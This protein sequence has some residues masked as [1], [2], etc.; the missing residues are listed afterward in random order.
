MAMKTNVGAIDK[1][2][3]IGVGLLL[4]LLT[5]TGTIGWW[6]WIG[7]VPLVTGV[8]GSCPAYALLGLNTCPLQGKSE[9]THETSS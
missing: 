2:I 3:R 5:L 9:G 8:M 1:S 6:G 7:V 4:V